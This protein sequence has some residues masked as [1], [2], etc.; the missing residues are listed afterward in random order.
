MNNPKVVHCKVALEGSFVY[1]GRPTKWGNPF[2][3]KEGTNAQYKVDTRE[4]AVAKYQEWICYGEGQHLLDDLEELKGQDLGCWCAPNRC[5]ADVLLWLANMNICR[6]ICHRETHVGI[7]HMF[8]CCDK[9][10]RPYLREDGSI[11]WEIYFE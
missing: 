2:S 10:Y 9:C 6:C 7:R 8:P 4:E 5:H 11:N 3:H 1:V